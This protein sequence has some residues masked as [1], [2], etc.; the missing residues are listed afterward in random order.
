[1]KT[2]A[3]DVNKGIP[4]SPLWNVA[5]S[6]PY[7]SQS[8]HSS[9]WLALFSRRLVPGMLEQCKGLVEI[10]GGDGASRECHSLN[11]EASHS[12]ASF[13]IRIWPVL[14]PPP[15]L[16]SCI[17]H[18]CELVPHGAH[19]PHVSQHSLTGLQRG[20]WVIVSGIKRISCQALASLLYQR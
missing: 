8:E 3:C 6:L 4:Q 17:R 9:P 19:K 18:L 13:E 5:S 7:C 14:Q 12:P 20:L 16:T 11:F 10:V 2:R 1:M 15:L